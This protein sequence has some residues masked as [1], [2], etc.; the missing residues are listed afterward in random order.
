MNF[1]WRVVLFF[2]VF[3]FGKSNA[4]V[5]SYFTNQPV[6]N[7]HSACANNP[8][9]VE[10]E[11]KNYF[12]NGDSIVN[13][14]V[15]KKIYMKGQG[16]L[17][18]INFPGGSCSGSYSYIDTIPS[19]L[20]R[21]QDKKMYV[22]MSYDTSEYLLYDFD[23]EIGDTLTPTH[24]CNLNDIYVIGI[25]SIA[26]PNGYLKKFELSNNSSARY[27]LEGIGNSNGLIEPFYTVF[28]CAFS[29]NCYSLNDSSYYP[30]GGLQCALSTGIAEPV[31]LEHIS[32]FPNPG[33]G[34]TSFQINSSVK[35]ATLNIYNSVGELINKLNW[36]EGKKFNF[37]TEKLSIGIYF[38]NIIQENK[39]IAKGKLII[40]KN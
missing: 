22:R 1:I 16:Y 13:N 28:E 10:H 32:V 33:S 27:L 31:R 19:L 38:L 18:S 23:L 15:Y 7:V 11:T 25:D 26:T 40:L 20:L 35:N 24:Y 21:S 12:I 37:G 17:S 34:L 3:G 14:L 4:Q 29:L 30:F 5:N 36:I 2:T 9:C 6:W 8:N 39:L